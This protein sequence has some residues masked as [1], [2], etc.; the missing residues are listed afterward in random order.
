LPWGDAEAHLWRGGGVF[1]GIF[2][3]GG[4]VINVITIEREYG[5]GAAGIARK[6]ADLLGWKLWDQLL[7][8]EVARHLACE[9]S[10]IEQREER[11]DPLYYRLLKSF[12]RGS[13]E[14]SLNAP[15]MK[16]ADAEGIRRITERLVQA[17]ATEGDCVIVGRG[18]AYYLR[19]LPN[20]FHVFIYAPFEDKVRRLEREGKRPEEAVEL[21]ETVDLERAAF[22][23]KYFG[24]EWPSRQVFQLMLNSALGEDTVVG[25]VLDCISEVNQHPRPARN[26]GGI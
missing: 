11:R 4:F 25:T 19:D 18:S 26:G 6:L 8:N 13:F 16:I 7:T 3:R 10:Q 1:T 12:L 22:I 5:S 20:A 15:R 9:S 24:I 14:G 2:Q 21:A 23:K 17:A